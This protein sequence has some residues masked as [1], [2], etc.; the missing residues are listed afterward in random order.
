MRYWT[1]SGCWLRRGRTSSSASNDDRANVD[2]T[3]R[4]VRSLKSVRRIDILP[5][6]RGG[7]AKSVR[8]AGDLDLMQAEVPSDD[9]INGIAGTLRGYGFEVKI[10]G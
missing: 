3:A 2:A 6:N 9:I 1:I 7:L 10:G 8:L 5:Y 4:F